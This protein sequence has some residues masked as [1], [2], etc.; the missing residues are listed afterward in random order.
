MKKSFFKKKMIVDSMNR[1]ELKFVDDERIKMLFNS[2]CY[3]STITVI[4]IQKE[5]IC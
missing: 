2:T 1:I 5:K 4:Y 3:C